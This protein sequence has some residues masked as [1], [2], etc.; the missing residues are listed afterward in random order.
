M[1]IYIYPVCLFSESR[2]EVA[3]H[4]HISQSGRALI[5][6]TSPFPFTQLALPSN[7]DGPAGQEQLCSGCCGSLTC[8]SARI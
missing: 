2:R 6:L 3:P 8:P 1:C 7:T 4:Y 5:G